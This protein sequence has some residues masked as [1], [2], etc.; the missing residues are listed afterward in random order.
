[1]NTV[2]HKLDLQHQVA[3]KSKNIVLDKIGNKVY[4]QAITEF[5]NKIDDLVWCH[6]WDQIDDDLNGMR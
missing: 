1:M 4:A 2:K 5:L 3:P 6:L